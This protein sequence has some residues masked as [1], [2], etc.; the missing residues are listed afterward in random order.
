LIKLDL[1]VCLVLEYDVD[2]MNPLQQFQI[3]IAHW[4]R[5]K[6]S[7]SEVGEHWDATQDYDEI[8]SETYSYFRRFVDGLALSDIPPNSHVLDFCARTGNGTAFFYKHGKVGSAVCVDVSKKMGEI[9]KQRVKESG[10]QDLSWMQVDD[11]A[12][13]FPDSEFD[14]VLCFETVEHFSEP[15]TLV[16]ELGRVTRPGGILVLT[17]P[18]VLWEPVH[19][20]A[21]ICG[22]HHSEGPH[23]F[24]GYHRLE[25]MIQASGF[26]IDKEQ[27]TVLIP[28]G[29]AFLV[30][31]GE[32]IEQRTT[33]TLMPMLGLRR[34]FIGRKK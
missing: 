3:E 7:F 18:N 19:A 14:A 31:F 27:T 25:R 15:E 2:K 32:W 12:L 11:Y 10:L 24:I 16:L 22:F 28:G 20:L 6:W 33:H 17:T 30:R 26:I 21:A 9:C 5:K 1:S 29:P 13:P 34:I 8:N 23:R 4:R